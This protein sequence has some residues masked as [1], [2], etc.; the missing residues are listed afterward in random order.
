MTSS[1]NEQTILTN[2]KL[3]FLEMSHKFFFCPEKYFP[4]NSREINKKSPTF[5]GEGLSQV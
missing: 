2:L 4:Q 5:E 3:F 1:Q